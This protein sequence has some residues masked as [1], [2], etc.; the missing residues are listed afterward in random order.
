MGFASIVAHLPAVDKPRLLSSRH[1]PVTAAGEGSVLKKNE[2]RK[3]EYQRRKKP[4]SPGNR[5]LEQM[6]R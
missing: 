5:A 3:G 6:V 2:Q 1:A 4:G